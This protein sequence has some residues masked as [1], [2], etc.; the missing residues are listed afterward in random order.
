MNLAERCASGV[1]ALQTLVNQWH[2]GAW[3]VW[4]QYLYQLL[5]A[6]TAVHARIRN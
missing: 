1:K 2:T 3:T 4:P 5:T 6:D